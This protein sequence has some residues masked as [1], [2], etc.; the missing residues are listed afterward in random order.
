LTFKVLFQNLERKASFFKPIFQPGL[1]DI[2]CR[3]TLAYLANI[4]EK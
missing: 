2:V 3:M 1:E 4:N